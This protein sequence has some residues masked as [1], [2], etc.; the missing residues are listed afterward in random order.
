[1]ETLPIIQ[2]NATN[3]TYTKEKQRTV[4]NVKENWLLYLSMH[5]DILLYNDISKTLKFALDWA[6]ILVNANVLFFSQ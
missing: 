5:N 4:F 2:V 1:L 6:L 3:T